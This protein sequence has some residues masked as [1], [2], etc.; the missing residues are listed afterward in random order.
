M[1][2][3][4]IEAL[5]VGILVVIIGLLIHLSANYFMKHDL[6]NLVVYSA[7]LFVIGVAV[8]LFCEFTNINKYYCKHG[9][10]CK[11]LI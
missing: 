10:A 3:Y 11:K 7:H 6:N 2:S 5:I 9:D 8:H 4:K 1:A